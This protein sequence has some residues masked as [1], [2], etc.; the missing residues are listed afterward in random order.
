MAL[1]LLLLLLSSSPPLLFSPFLSFS[2]LFSP[3]LSFSLLFSPFLSFSLLFS[4]F[5]SF[6]LSHSSCPIRRPTFLFPS[7]LN[8]SPLF[9]PPPLPSPLSLPLFSLLP[10]P[11]P[12]PLSFF[13]E[14]T[15]LLLW[16]HPHGHADFDFHAWFCVDLHA[17][18][19]RAGSTV[20]K[21]TSNQAFGRALFT[22]KVFGSQLQVL[23]SHFFC[24]L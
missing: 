14:R 13:S 18:L 17:K 2:L 15:C 19:Y 8:C 23:P 22:N 10:V 3:F 1:L 21:V 4:P 24:I 11:P 5:L 16:F 6:S 12:H 9:C 20:L 7:S